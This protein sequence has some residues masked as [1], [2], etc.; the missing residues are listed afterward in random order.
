MTLQDI[1]SIS[2]IVASWVGIVYTLVTLFSRKKDVQNS[3]SNYEDS[4]KY[5]ITELMRVL[6]KYVLTSCLFCFA[7]YSNVSNGG[8]VQ[9]I[10][11]LVI[12]GC[13]GAIILL[14][15]RMMYVYTMWSAIREL[16]KD[17]IAY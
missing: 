2:V 3:S 17:N 14:L 1:E 8:A 9:K 11:I 16:R 6:W 12:S 7:I 10:D 13:I 4:S 5:D 15:V